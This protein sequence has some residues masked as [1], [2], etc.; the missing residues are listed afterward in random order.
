GGGGGGGGERGWH[1][2]IRVT[3]AIPPEA[4][5]ITVSVRKARLY[6]DDPTSCT[7]EVDLT[8]GLTPA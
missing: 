6:S 2:E 1:G 4:H 3:P 8:T 5:R 7:F